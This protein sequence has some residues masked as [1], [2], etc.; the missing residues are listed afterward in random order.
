[1]PR[2]L[3]HYPQSITNLSVI[4]ERSILEESGLLE[5]TFI[6][7][8]NQEAPLVLDELSIPPPARTFVEADRPSFINTRT[9]SNSIEAQERENVWDSEDEEIKQQGGRALIVCLKKE[10]EKEKKHSKQTN[11]LIERCLDR[12]QSR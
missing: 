11:E 5:Q 8:E 6:E 9:R 1:M 4:N 3:L 2:S 10:R 12:D 7:D